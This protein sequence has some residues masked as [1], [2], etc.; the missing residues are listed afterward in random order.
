MLDQVVKYQYLLDLPSHNRPA[1]NS[2][3]GLGVS[4]VKRTVNVWGPHP[5]TRVYTLPKLRI[6]LF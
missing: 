6:F 5:D 2:I 4:L 1:F 3:A